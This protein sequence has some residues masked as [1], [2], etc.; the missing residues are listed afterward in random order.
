MNFGDNATFA[1]R[2]SINLAGTVM[3]L[4]SGKTLLVNGGL[5]TDT[6]NAILGTGQTLHD[7]KRRTLGCRRGEP[8]RR[9]AHRHRRRFTLH[10]QQHDRELTMVRAGLER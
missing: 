9:H 1:T 6:T 5:V 2:S 7:P 10:H 8:A 3:T 4:P